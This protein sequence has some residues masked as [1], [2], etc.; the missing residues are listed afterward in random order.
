MK[1]LYTIV[2]KHSHSSILQIKN[3]KPVLISAR[4]LIILSDLSG[5]VCSYEFS[6][7]RYPDMIEPNKNPGQ[8]LTP[9][10]ICKLETIFVEGY[11][12]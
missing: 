6:L 10:Q 12:D 8:L 3:Q 2:N 9:R 1:L 5:G 7:C 11:Q 4:K